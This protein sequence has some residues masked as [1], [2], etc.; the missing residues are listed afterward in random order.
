MEEEQS[1]VQV[2]RLNLVGGKGRTT[3]VSAKNVF[4][5][6]EGQSDKDF[7]KSLDLTDHDEY[8]IVTKNRSADLVS[9]ENVPRLE[10][11][12]G[13]GLYDFLSSICPPHFRE[14]ELDALHADAI[15]LYLEK[16]Q[17]GDNWGAWRV[18]WAMR[19]WLLWTVFGG[20]AGA[21]LSVITGKS[22]P[23]K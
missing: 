7:L 20:A 19:G 16:L 14:R 12:P 6:A 9:H 13:Y 10:V 1:N 17:A 8:R 3:L 18:K 4:I 5:V 21:L 2:V 23:S 15:Q 22:K 11:A